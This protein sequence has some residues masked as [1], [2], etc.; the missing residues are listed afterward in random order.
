MRWLCPIVLACVTV[1]V[2]ADL[3]AGGDE[4]RRKR[5]GVDPERRQQLLEKFDTDGDGKLDP[6]ERAAAR[7]ARRARIREKLDTNGDGEVS[8]DERARFRDG[9]ARCQ[10]RRGGCGPRGRRGRG[11]LR[12]MR[13]AADRDGDGAVSEEERNAA[14]KALRARR[15]EKLD[16]NGDGKLSDDEEASA[17]EDR[18]RCRGRRGRSGPRGRRLS[19]HLRRMRAAA[20]RDGDG[21]VSEEERNTARKAIRAFLSE[22]FDVDGDGELSDEE[23]AAMR[24]SRPRRRGRFGPP[25]RRFG[26]PPESR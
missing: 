5:R 17:R 11:R 15:L 21:V 18:P 8:E 26:G 13:K 24:D 12:S 14:R 9:H 7:E 22:K 6:D 25:R 20:D 19:G 10:G 3:L 2:S 4:G 1:V 23:K 16:A